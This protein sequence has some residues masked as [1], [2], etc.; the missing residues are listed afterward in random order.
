MSETETAPGAI[1]SATAEVEMPRAFPE[2]N[3][4]IDGRFEV[5]QRRTGDLFDPNSGQPLA[6]NRS[7]SLEQ[8]ER[9]IASAHAAHESAEWR[10][11]GIAGRA[12]LL[13]AFAARLDE[14]GEQ[15]A[16]LDAVNSGVPISVTRL[17][18]GSAGDTVRDVAERALALGDSRALAADGRDVR[19]RRVPWGATAL[20]MPW[21][22]PSAMAVKKLGY[23]LAAGA[24]VVMKPSPAS[25][26]STVLVAR[27]AVESGIPRGVVNLVLG[28]GDIGAALVSDPRIRA[29]SMTGSTPTG[30]AIA[31]SA[32]A[33]L[34]RLRLELGS[35]NP[36]IVRA[37][38]NVEEAARVI[39]AGAMKLSGQWCEAP[40]RVIVAR[41]L[42]AGL[43]EALR[44]E[45]SA[46]RI[47]SSLDEGTE[48]GPVAFRDRLIELEGQRAALEAQGA[49]IH[50]EGEVPAEG[51]FFQPTIAVAE[52]IDLELELFGPLLT[53]QPSD[54]D[55][56]ALALANAGHVGL[57]GY[58]FGEDEQAALQ[59]GAGLLAGEVK[60]NGSS[61][62]DMAAESKQSFFGLSGLG[63]HGDAD[64]LD[65]FSGTQI[66]GTDRPGMPL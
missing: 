40:R 54:S 62:L 1:T 66:V 59:L 20:I 56:Q 45:L 11:M 37:D 17:F 2:L 36:A 6:E 48:L 15:I 65:F 47:G 61:V 32:G 57:A 12:P 22:A 4:V 21:N 8:L 58:V 7:S 55:E 60:I 3:T 51:W 63:G 25:P 52:E 18:A 13:R 64:V 35:N 50:R 29:I 27:A 30:R 28:G 10:G 44:G 43:V 42:L 38:A 39:V 34:T 31:A 53:V 33:N 5:S 41:P 19:L 26:W 24:S 9:A 49:L 16:V 46:L 23:A 14:L